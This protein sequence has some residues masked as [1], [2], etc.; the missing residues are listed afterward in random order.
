MPITAFPAASVLV[1]GQSIIGKSTSGAGICSE[2]SPSDVRTLIGAQAT[3]VSG[4]SIKTINGT[5]LLGS[6]DITI[7]GGSGSPGGSSTQIQFNSSGAFAGSPNLTWNGS[8]LSIKRNGVNDHAVLSILP[9]DPSPGYRGNLPWNL[10]VYQNASTNAPNLSYNMVVTCGHNMSP[11]GDRVSNTDSAIGWS[12]EQ[13]WE[14]GDINAGGLELTEYHD[15]YIARQ[16]ANGVSAG[17]QVRLMS[18]TINKD[19]NGIDFYNTVNNH[20]LKHP[21]YATFGTEANAIYWSVAPSQ[22]FLRT[23]AEGANANSVSFTLTGVAGVGSGLLCQ[24]VTTG[25]FNFLSPVSFGTGF[26]V[27][28]NVTLTAGSLTVGGSGNIICQNTAM[29]AMICLG[30]IS[31]A[32][33]CDIGGLPARL[34]KLTSPPTN[35]Y[36]GQ[37]GLLCRDNGSGKMQLVAIFPTGT[38]KILATED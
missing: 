9:N 29:N 31:T 35:T 37:I 18:Y 26:N 23:L 4:T 27:G 33:G 24:M 3:L 15:F 28:G 12:M 21:S 7:S 34:V 17:Q 10:N 20:Y 8:G 11:G 2:L 5:S 1:S 25:T 38:V 14:S 22:W 32:Q 13:S 30:G 36:T 16:T 6:G 19:S